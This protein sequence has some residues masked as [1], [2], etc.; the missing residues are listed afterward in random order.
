MVPR[1]RRGKQE[2]E[3]A[4]NETKNK[5]NKTTEQEHTIIVMGERINYKAKLGKALTQI[6]PLRQKKLTRQNQNGRQG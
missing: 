4:E 3:H 6:Y 1:T 2:K 5:P